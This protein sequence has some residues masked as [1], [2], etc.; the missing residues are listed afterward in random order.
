MK[1]NHDTLHLLQQVRTGVLTPEDALL[2]L[3]LAPFE[4]LGYAKIDSHR[5][6]RRQN[7]G[8]AAGH[9]HCYGSTG[10]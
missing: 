1:G 10:R 5:P 9:P 2:Q 3:K 8:T 4:D 6:I 7:T